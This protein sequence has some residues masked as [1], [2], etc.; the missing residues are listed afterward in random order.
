MATTAATP[1]D[2]TPKQDAKTEPKLSK[3]L[4]AALDS[5]YANRKVPSGYAINFNAKPII[6]KIEE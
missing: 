3:E 4:Q 2:T 1:A 5:F 6:S